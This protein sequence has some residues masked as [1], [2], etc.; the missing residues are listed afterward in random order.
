MESRLRDITICLPYYRNL[1]MLQ[2]QCR[3]F[4]NL[5][6]EIKSHLRLIVVDDGS[7]I[8]QANET[9][10]PDIARAAQHEDIGFPFSLFRINV[11]IRWNQDA[12]RNIAVKHADTEWLLLGD[13]DH[14]VPETTLRSLLEDKFDPDRAYRFSRMTL[15]KDGTVDDYKMHPNTWFMTRAVYWKIGGYDERLAGLYGSDGDFRSRVTA[16]CGAPEQLDRVIIR[17][18]RET[19]PDASTSTYERKTPAD[20]QIK[21]I[22]TKRNHTPGWKPE[23]FRFPYERVA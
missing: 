22:L 1:G 6:P 5:A 13:M 2:E 4:R 15:H 20:A 9:E 12:A 3:R 10:L 18:P 23:H 21:E 19:I 8:L 14:I 11:N 16:Q 17:V 7:T